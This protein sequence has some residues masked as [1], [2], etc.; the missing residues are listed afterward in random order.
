MDAPSQPTEAV[1]A[2]HEKILGDAEEI[3]RKAGEETKKLMQ[4]I[5]KLRDQSAARR[6]E[7]ITRYKPL[8][9]ARKNLANAGKDISSKDRGALEKIVAEK[10]AEAWQRYLPESQWLGA[11]EYA[12]AGRYYNQPYG[13]YISRHVMAELGG[14]EMRENLNSLKSLLEVDSKPEYWR[15][16]V[17]WDW[18]LPEEIS[19]KID[20]LPLM[21]KWLL[22]TRGPV[23][24]DDPSEK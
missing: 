24:N 7:L 10:E 19:G 5:L 1:L 11:F 6:E 15:T 13:S 23:V 20:D 8:L 12:C 18:R 21:K 4:P 2:L 3:A 9:E 22:K 16:E 17:D 14:G